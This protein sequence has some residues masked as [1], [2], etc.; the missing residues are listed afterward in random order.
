M[1]KLTELNAEEV[2]PLPTLLEASYYLPSKLKK[3]LA[4]STTHLEEFGRKRAAHIAKSDAQIALCT[5][6]LATAKATR[7]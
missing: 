2:N 7:K 5:H 3:F 1:T 6:R 4:T